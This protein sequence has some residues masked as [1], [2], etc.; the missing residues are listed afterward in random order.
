MRGGFHAHR[1]D[2]P[3]PVCQARRGERGGTTQIHVAYKLSGAA[4]AWLRAKAAE[5]L[6]SPSRAARSLLLDEMEEQEGRR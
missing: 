5:N 6:C 2:C 3:C 4:A 1:A